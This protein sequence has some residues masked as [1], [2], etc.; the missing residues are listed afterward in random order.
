M[1]IFATVPEPRVHV[2]AAWEGRAAAVAARGV[3]VITVSARTGP[4]CEG[5]V[6]AAVAAHRWGV[7]AVIRAGPAPMSG[8]GAAR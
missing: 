1:G 8:R 3:G 4:A 2:I 6:L 5:G 7:A